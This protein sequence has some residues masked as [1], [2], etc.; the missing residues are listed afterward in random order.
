MQTQKIPFSIEKMKDAV[1]ID[2]MK[3]AIRY[4]TRDGREV[5]Q[6]T[7]FDCKH[8]PIVVGLLS[9]TICTFAENG[10]HCLSREANEDLFIIIEKPIEY[11]CLCWVSSYDKNPDAESCCSLALMGGRNSELPT[12]KHWKYSTPL[13]DEELAELGL[14]RVEK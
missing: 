7:A 2:K 3:D 9:G 4:E 14:M 1:R 13:T 12:D 11:P 8:A 10:R 6:V 5:T